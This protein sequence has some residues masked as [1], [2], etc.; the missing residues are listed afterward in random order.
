MEQCLGTTTKGLRCKKLTDQK[1]CQYHRPKEAAAKLGEGELQKPVKEIPKLPKKSSSAGFIYIYTLE[2]FFSKDKDWFKVKNLPKS[3]TKSWVSYDYNKS[4]YI[5]LKIGMT[6]QNVQARLSQWEK[7]CNHKLVVVNPITDKAFNLKLVDYFK[8]LSVKDDEYMTF[9]GDGF[10]VKNHLS[11]A[12]AEI[13]KVLRELYGK[14]LVFCKGC[15]N[16]EASTSKSNELF[17]NGCN[18]HIE[19]FLVPKKGLKMVYQVI[20]Q[21]CSRYQ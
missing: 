15:I 11:Q 21:I 18:I 13:H 17:V 14:G 10:R 20:D 3:K 6:T 16:S 9:K 8:R 5:L 7:K 19:W 2:R 12:E 1:Y 4:D